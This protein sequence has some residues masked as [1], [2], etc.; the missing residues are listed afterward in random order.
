MS[1]L[2]AD[3]YVHD[4]SFLAREEQ[5]LPAGAWTHWLYLAGR[6]AGK[7]LALDVPILTKNRGWTVMGEIEEGDIV[8]DEKGAPTTVVQVHPILHNRKCYEVT[9][10]GG[11]SF[12]ADEEHLWTIHQHDEPVATA[13]LFRRASVTVCEPLQQDTVELPIDPYA[14]GVWI[15]GH[16]RRWNLLSESDPALLRALAKA[17]FKV[18]AG[19]NLN[20]GEDIF[21]LDYNKHIPDAYMF[22][23]KEARMALLSGIVDCAGGNSQGVYR[24]WPK[25]YFK[26]LVHSLGIKTV[27]EAGRLKFRTEMILTRIRH[28]VRHAKRF[29]PNIF[30]KRNYVNSVVETASVPVRCITVD[31]PSALYLITD[32]FLPTHNTRTGAENARLKVMAGCKRLGLI[33]PTSGDARDVMVE[34]ESGLLAVCWKGD[35][36]NDGRY[37]GVPLYEPS[38]RRLTWE[39]GAIGT[40]YSADEPERLRGPQHDYLWCFIS[41]TQVSTPT[42]TTPIQSLEP[43]KL[44]MTR[45]GPKPVIANAKRKA[46]VGK[47]TFSNGATLIGTADHPIYTDSGWVNLADLKV[48]EEVCAISSGTENFGT[49]TQEISTTNTEKK[50]CIEQCTSSTSAKFRKGLTCITK[51]TIQPTMT[52]TTLSCSNT[53]HTPVCT[54]RKSLYRKLT[55]R[56][57]RCL[58]YFA[59]IAARSCDVKP[60]DRMQG[61]LNATEN[62]QIGCAL[63]MSESACNV[64]NFLKQSVQTTAVSVVSIWQPMAEQDV[65]CL[66]VAETPE[67]FANSILVHNCDELCS[68]RRPETFDLAMFGLRLGVNPQTF[69]ST[70]PKPKKIIMELIKDPN[71]V[72]TRGSTYD[73]RANL[74]ENFFKTVI[75]KYEGTRLGE[76][77]LMGVVLEEAEGALWSREILDTTRVKEFDW[78][79][80]ALR[81]VVAVDPATSSTTGS[82]NECG[83]IVAAV[84]HDKQGY[85]LADFSGVYTPGEWAKKAVLA[86]NMYGADR[87]V[88]EGNQGGEMVRHTINTE[89]ISVPVKIVYAARGKIA[90]AEPIAA[91]FEQDRS[92]IVGSL[93]D[94]EDQLCTWEA[95]SGE[96]SPDR[97]DA[98]VW[99]LTELQIGKGITGVGTLIGA[100]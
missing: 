99:G 80:E 90:R 9:F 91:L 2:E 65:Y 55:G 89:D 73:N 37:M 100:F 56:I 69:I 24:I 34:G 43:G 62:E 95:L 32:L 6:G 30:V 93:Q 17:G 63:K 52:Q 71:C 15:G 39:N 88:A 86:Y 18:R 77:E 47:V 14:L 94:L 8:F 44:V 75:T 5:T 61:V 51:T 83:I 22:A 40:L 96:E 49:C 28:N 12:I 97:L 4:W 10:T 53:A 21:E 42:G 27:E 98:M 81:I 58:K 85:V 84:D 19:G 1:P 16:S 26:E 23:H 41:G 78:R 33:A 31:S 50:G 46:L 11:E 57:N 67:Y 29:K 68:W 38:K 36:D 87:I 70:T 45:E 25:P 66:K 72:V 82:S 35:K 3:A 60:S 54:S 48:D 20:L 7:A 13:S 76:Q 74:A 79:N 92:H 64:E 59:S